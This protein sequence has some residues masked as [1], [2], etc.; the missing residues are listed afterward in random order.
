VRQQLTDREL[1]NTID[2]DGC[3]APKMFREHLAARAARRAATC[4]GIQ[5]CHGQ[6]REWPARSSRNRAENGR[7]LG[8]DGQTVACRLDVAPDEQLTIGIQQRRADV[9][10]RIRRIRSGGN[11]A[12][13]RNE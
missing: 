11:L 9:E 4:L 6:R 8:A 10:T 2:E 12:R 3:I 5:A 13:S 7:A 1:T